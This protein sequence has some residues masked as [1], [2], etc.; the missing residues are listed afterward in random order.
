MRTLKISLAAVLALGGLLACASLVQAQDTNA[1]KKGERRG[2]MGARMADELNLDEAQKAKVQEA[3][4]EQGKK[5][6]ELREDTALT[7]EQRQEKMKAL[8]DDMDKKMKTILKPDQYEKWQ[9]NREQMRGQGGKKKG[10]E[11]KD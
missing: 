7:Q 9:K 3:F 2:Q 10:Q 11:K 1:A 8:R 4:Q 6:R 5:M